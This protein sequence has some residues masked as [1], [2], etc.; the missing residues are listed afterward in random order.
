MQNNFVIIE[1]KLT[2]KMI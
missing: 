1:R 2:F